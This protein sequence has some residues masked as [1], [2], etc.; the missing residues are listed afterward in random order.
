MSVEARMT[1]PTSSPKNKRAAALGGALLPISRPDLDNLAKIADALN[2]IV[3]V[4]DAQVVD[5]HVRK[6]Y[7]DTPALIIDVEPAPNFFA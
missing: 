7:S 3:W 2:L 6:T 4:D 1:V 5:L